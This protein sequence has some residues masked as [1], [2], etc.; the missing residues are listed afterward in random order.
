[1][2]RLDVDITDGVSPTLAALIAAMEGSELRE[3]NAV[4]GR[5]ARNAVVDYHRRFDQSG[6]WRGKRF[7]DAPSTGSS[8]GAD[9]AAGWQFRT[10]DETGATIS[11]D[12]D[13]FAFKVRGGTITPKRVSALT[14]PMIPEARGR[15]VADY[16]LMFRTKLF[17][18]RGKNALFERVGG[19][20][21]GERGTRRRTAGST[22]IRTSSIRAVYALVKSVTQGPWKGAMPPEED[23][24]TAFSMAWRNEMI[25]RIS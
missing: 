13:H 19:Q 17:Q 18:I 4:G 24:A 1:M 6:G 9:V 23:I 5:A 25:R 10:A 12:A 2:I 14:L 16:E 21:T 22:Q 3:L 15:R 20:T 8:F 11:N 7:A